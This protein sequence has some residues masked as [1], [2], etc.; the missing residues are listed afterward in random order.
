MKL[1]IQLIVSFFGIGFLPVIPGTLVTLTA[2]PIFFLLFILQINLLKVI[3]PLAVVTL[4]FYFLYTKK[5]EEGKIPKYFTLDKISGFLTTMAFIETPYPLTIVI[6]GFI[7]FRF[8]DIVK[9]I[10]ISR[11][12]TLPYGLGIPIATIIAG[13]YANIILQNICAF[14]LLD[15]LPAAI[16]F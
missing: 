1:I 4:V 13:L 7:L 5:F 14:G 9:P 3:I 2:I 15:K 6:L 10:P 8:F 12:R 11:L 16:L